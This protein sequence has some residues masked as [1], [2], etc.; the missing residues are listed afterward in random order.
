[1]CCLMIHA[2][3][4]MNSQAQVQQHALVVGINRYQYADGTNLTNLMGAVNDAKLIY[5]TLQ[6]SE[7]EGTLLLN[8]KATKRNFI[9]AWQAMVA[10][11][12]KGDTL[13]ITFAGHGSQIDD[14]RPIDEQDGQDEALVFY[15]YDFAGD[16]AGLLY[17][18]ELF[19]LFKQASDYNILVLIDACHSAGMIRS[20]RPAQ[21]RLLGQARFTRA[22]DNLNL[23]RRKRSLVLPMLADTSSSLPHVTLITAVDNES[24]VVNEVMINNKPHGALSWFFVNAIRGNA[25]KNANKTLER[26]E[27]KE[28]LHKK[29]RQYTNNRQTPQLLPRADEVS[30]VALSR[31]NLLQPLQPTPQPVGQT[32]IKILADQFTPPRGLSGVKWVTSAPFELYVKPHQR[33]TLEVLNHTGDRI[34]LLKRPTLDT[35]QRLIDRQQL[36]AFLQNYATRSDAIRL[37]LQEGDM[38]HRHGT[39]LNFTVDT[40]DSRL[41]ALTVFNLS[42]QGTLQFL[43]PY[44]SDAKTVKLPHALPPI[45]VDAPFGSDTVIA[46]LCRQVPTSLQLTLMDSQ[47]T[48]PDLTELR[49]LLTANQCQVADYPFFTAQ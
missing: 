42:G 29:I 37:T 18:D 5:A 17:D 8:A 28:F 22:P 25:D 30:V 43:Y 38:L 48:L 2:L 31:R 21:S 15:E 27:L 35:W 34:A 41:N 39:L 7:I 4:S 19:G 32:A 16:G 49:L 46:V 10:N 6:D 9:N 3:W 14:Q 36:I 24:L 13:I 33:N 45:Q 1:M 40:T 20:L 11:A 47:A 12:R 23:N 26:Q 44:P